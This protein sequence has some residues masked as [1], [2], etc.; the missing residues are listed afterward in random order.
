MKS[1]SPYFGIATGVE[2]TIAGRLR[3]RA[4]T[5]KAPQE[6]RRADA[7]TLQ[8]AASIDGYG[9]HRAWRA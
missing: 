8:E 5:A 6:Q 2:Q 9:R 4:S 7:S 1:G 3:P